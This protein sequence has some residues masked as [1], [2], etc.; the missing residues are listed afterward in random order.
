MC[1]AGISELIMCFFSSALTEEGVSATAA[2]AKSH[3]RRFRFIL[4]TRFT[5]I[6]FYS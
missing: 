5:L 6:L 2:M 4:S 1:G 3:V